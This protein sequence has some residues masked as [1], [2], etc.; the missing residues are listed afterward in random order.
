M[1]ILQVTEDIT[2]V[3]RKMTALAAVNDEEADDPF[4]D[5]D[6]AFPL[7][8]WRKQPEDKEDGLIKQVYLPR[9]HHTFRFISQPST[10]ALATLDGLDGAKCDD[11]VQALHNV[12]LLQEEVVDKCFLVKCHRVPVIFD[13]LGHD[14]TTVRLAALELCSRLV[15]RVQG[16]GAEHHIRYNQLH[17]LQ[18]C[19]PSS[20]NAFISS[21]TIRLGWWT[22]W[23]P[24]SR[25]PPLPFDSKW[26]RCCGSS[27]ARRTATSSPLFSPRGAVAC[28]LM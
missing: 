8:D 12:L 27:S 11:F 18:V 25:Q 3:A 10:Q 20:S 1:Y 2:L 24:A 26:L 21:R 16:G 6:D 28:L 22:L 15:L 4:A 23:T 13:A 14:N 7:E 19:F 9:K 5:L 17:L